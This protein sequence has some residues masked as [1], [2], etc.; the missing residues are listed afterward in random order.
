MVN[1][2]NVAETDDTWLND[3]GQAEC[4]MSPKT[5]EA[6]TDNSPCKGIKEA[7]MNAEKAYNA[8]V[9]KMMAVA[10]DAM[11]QQIAKM[12]EDFAA[13]MKDL[14]AKYRQCMSLSTLTTNAP[15]CCMALTA[16]CMAC[17]KGM[18]VE[19]YC[20][21][22]PTT[23]GCPAVV[24]ETT[25]APTDN[26][27]CKGIKEAM[28]KAEKDYNAA[29]EKMSASDA[30]V[31]QMKERFAAQMKDL[32]AQY[33]RCMSLSP[34]TDKPTCSGATQDSIN[35][36]GGAPRCAMYDAFCRLAGPPLQTCTTVHHTMPAEIDCLL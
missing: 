16:D 13:Q 17:A 34:P 9:E 28:M 11:V 12:K 26:S 5:T 31:Q 19:E 33:K 7:M 3:M 14:T 10:S 29:V 22:A 36:C 15:M 1:M 4:D 25:A 27:P 24:K 23:M 30:M 32:T 18:S 20:K 6:P 21:R 8:A 2:V 35:D